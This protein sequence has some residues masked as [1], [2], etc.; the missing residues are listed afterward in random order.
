[1]KNETRRERERQV[2]EGDIVAAAEK[3]FAQKGFNDASMDEIAQEAQFTKRTLYLYFENKE[4]LFFAAAI[5]GFKM[6]LVYLQKASEKEQTGFMKIFQGSRG[7]YRFY[8]EFPGTL[9]LIGEIGQ[10]K[11]KTKKDSQR[12]QELMQIDNEIFQW[13]ARVIA[14]GKVDKSI[15]DDL[16]EKKVTFSIVFM[17][18][19]FFNQLSMTGDTY[20]EYFALD[21]EEFSEYS[22]NLLFDSIKNKRK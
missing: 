2:R 5:N 15:R 8:K 20:M 12:L 16:D 18:T 19:G 21:H 9:R 1:M 6:L 4:E 17:M 3:V 14:E 13:V 11:N 10:V 7:Y 22:M